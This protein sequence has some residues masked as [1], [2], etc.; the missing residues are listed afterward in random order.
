M[1]NKFRKIN[2]ASLKTLK[3]AICKQNHEFQKTIFAA[4][5]ADNSA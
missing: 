2:L 3:L 1:L 4:Y 5:F